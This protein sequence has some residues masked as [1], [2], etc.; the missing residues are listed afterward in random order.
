M[1]DVA[2]LFGR[3]LLVALLYLFLLAAVRAGLGLVKRGAPSQA[4]APLEL[5]VT[6]GPQELVGVRLSLGARVRIGR[7]PGHELSIADDF[8]S[9]DHAEVVPGPDGPVLTDLGS[10]NGTLVNDVRVT[11]PTL[12]APGDDVEVGTVRMKVSRP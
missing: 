1:V 7:S 4:V 2:L 12:L 3:I 9:T 6:A 8:V 10:T 5:V 11:A